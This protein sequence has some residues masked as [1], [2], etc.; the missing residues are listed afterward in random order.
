MSSEGVAQ[1]QNVSPDLKKS[2]NMVR[3]P[4]SND[5]IKNNPLQMCPAVSI[6]ID[7]W[8]GQDVNQAE[9]P[10]LIWEGKSRKE[11]EV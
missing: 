2:L 10:L 1:I 7:S 8:Y 5:P 9:T 4:T 3:P 11:E 6:L